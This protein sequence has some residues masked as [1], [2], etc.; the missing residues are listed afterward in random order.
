MSDMNA[1]VSKID[2]SINNCLA[3]NELDEVLL[4]TCDF[5][6]TVL[7]QHC[8]P[9][10][11]YAFIKDVTNQIDD[12]TFTKDG[13]NIV[14][15]LDFQT[16][17]QTALKNA[18]AHIGSSVEREAA[19]GTTSSMMLAIS[20]LKYLRMNPTIRKMPVSMLVSAWRFIEQEVRRLYT[21]GVESTE[22]R[23]NPVIRMH[24]FPGRDAEDWKNHIK[25]IAYSQTYTSSHGDTEFA[26]V[27]AEM[28]SKVPESAWKTIMVRRAEYET[29]ENYNLEVDTS[30]WTFNKIG[31][32]PF[33]QRLTENLEG[34]LRRKNESC[35]ICQRAPLLAGDEDSKELMKNIVESI[36]NNHNITYICNG[37][38]DANSLNCLSQL[39][40]E[41]PSCPTTIIF[42]FSEKNGVASDLE[43]MPLLIEGYNGQLVYPITLDYETN[44][45]TF[46]ILK[47][48]HNF[49]S[50]PDLLCESHPWLYD[51]DP[52]HKTYSE[53]IENL[54]HAL[55]K[56]NKEYDISKI[57]QNWY[58]GVKILY[59]KLTVINRVSFVIGGS[60]YNNLTAVD[61]VHDTLPAV[62]RTLEK[63]FCRG[64]NKSLYIALQEVSDKINNL[65]LDDT[66]E[67][68]YMKEVVPF[69]C[70]I[71]MNG[72]E[73]LYEI[74]HQVSLKKKKDQSAKSGQ[75]NPELF[76]DAISGK[77]WSDVQAFLDD[78]STKT[79]LII[80]PINT[81][82]EFMKRFGEMMIRFIKTNKMITVGTLISK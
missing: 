68:K 41:N 39:Y 44:G 69:I 63:G 34:I 65:E 72:I 77:S 31:I 7:S 74:T 28:F 53:F 52:K 16:P 18:I 26:K 59:N 1:S 47:G 54:E 9:L 11:E 24:D 22:G 36:K 33:D 27:V 67:S 40:A 51:G 12:G 57:N 73:N 82:L 75:F 4:K 70:R 8:G 58:E 49:E 78:E 60:L 30:E 10:S 42:I 81:D 19:D 21:V 55:D 2:S 50:N 15:S 3:N 43:T 13:I 79:G 23:S 35:F 45:K 6:Y 5:I 38:V 71:L 61:I 17:I 25:K 64:E 56:Q 32:H 14:R 80:Q 20:T 29:D 48:L 46:K 37:N 76:E 66:A 62:R